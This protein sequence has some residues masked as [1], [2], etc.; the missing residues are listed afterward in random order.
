MTKPVLNFSIP[1]SGHALTLHS[2]R[3]NAARATH[4][5]S[6]APTT[7]NDTY[8]P[9]H[10][11]EQ[12]VE[13]FQPI[14]KFHARRLR[15]P[16]PGNLFINN[17][18]QSIDDKALRDAFAGFGNVVRCGVMT[19]EHGR[20]KGYGWVHYATSEA[21]DRAFSA[22]KGNVLRDKKVSV[23]LNAS[24]EER[25]ERFSK[26]KPQFTDLY[27]K[28]L[29]PTTTKEAL[30]TLFS[31]YGTVTFAT[32][33]LDEAGKS[34]CSGFVRY[35]THTEAQKAIDELHDSG[36]RRQKLLVR[37]AEKG[38]RQVGLLQQELESLMTQYNGLI[39]YVRNLEPDMDDKT[40]R[41]NFERFGAVTSINIM[42]T[43]Q[44]KS[45]RFGFVVFAKPADAARA[46]ERMDGK[47]MGSTPLSV[48]LVG[49][50]DVRNHKFGTA[51]AGVLTPL[52]QVAKLV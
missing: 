44:G 37:C 3:L 35:A 14:N 31:E 22:M 29:D 15:K 38:E 12:T 47:V 7:K 28:G 11:D 26:L 34:K 16:G 46:V 4:T 51:V 10:I 25:E 13:Q 42:R 32:I 45:R 50:D 5:H 8:P 49:G 20:S 52:A 40:L 48:A 39:L 19:D 18:N 27:V 41:S 1:V 6:P 43:A 21:A 9:T 2:L 36:H 24:S 17:L 23:F 30:K 33:P